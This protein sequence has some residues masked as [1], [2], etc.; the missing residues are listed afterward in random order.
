MR[1]FYGHFSDL[2][3]EGSCQVRTES[4]QLS[5]HI[6][7]HEN[8]IGEFA[9][10]QQMSFDRT[11]L[12]KPF[13][14]RLHELWKETCFEAFVSVRGAVKYWE[15]NLSPKGNWNVYEFEDYRQPQPPRES[16]RL[17]LRKIQTSVD[18]KNWFG[19]FELSCVGL[20][21]E[22]VEFNLCAVVRSLR[23][24]DFKNDSAAVSVGEAVNDYYAIDHATERPDFH[25]RDCIRQK[26]RQKDRQ[27]AE[28]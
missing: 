18:S 11:N 25:R 13:P 10:F 7:S 27:K 19:N 5:F 21:A 28:Q 3:L 26:D 12:S 6:Q 1:P 24:K 2:A 8:L 9:D 22:D 17:V 16:D 4:L 15:L 23:G 14:Q 20:A